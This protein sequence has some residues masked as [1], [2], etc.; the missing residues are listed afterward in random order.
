MAK[1]TH[2]AFKCSPGTS[3]SSSSTVA[4]GALP[5]AAVRGEKICEQHEEE[6][7]G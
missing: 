1:I 6:G 3:S 2:C 5:S 7:S 4:I